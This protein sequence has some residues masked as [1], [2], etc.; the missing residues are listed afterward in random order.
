MNDW[1]TDKDAIATIIKL[2][3]LMPGDRLLLQHATRFGITQEAHK[4]VD[5]DEVEIDVVFSP[6]TLEAAWLLKT[7]K[8][9]VGEWKK[10]AACTIVFIQALYVAPFNIAA[11]RRPRAKT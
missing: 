3:G 6:P 7:E 1:T 2:G 5:G 8:E 4:L 11:W 9:Y 10:Y